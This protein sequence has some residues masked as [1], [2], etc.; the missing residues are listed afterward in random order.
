MALFVIPLAYQLAIAAGSAIGAYFV[1][2][3]AKEKE[4]TARRMQAEAER[5]HRETADALEANKSA[6]QSHL[7]VRQA[8]IR[9]R[10]EVLMARARPILATYE[11]PLRELGKLEMPPGFERIE[12]MTVPALPAAAVLFAIGDDTWRQQLSQA[13]GRGIWVGGHTGM[14]PG[15]SGTPMPNLSNAAVMGGLA[16]LGQ[17]ANRNM[18]ADQMLTHATEVKGQVEKF[19]AEACKLQSGFA[20]MRARADGLGEKLKE[21]SAFFER[22][23]SPCEILHGSGK[24]WVSLSPNDRLGVQH[25]AYVVEFLTK[26]T[27]EPLA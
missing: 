8:D 21:A 26:T 15:P 25:F 22:F 10:H 13:A 27:E 20:Q 1:N 2:E 18:N 14:S 12:Q 17:A 3:N 9:E 19:K 16:V 23:I 6:L 11:Q 7:L 4:Q 24:N 5:V